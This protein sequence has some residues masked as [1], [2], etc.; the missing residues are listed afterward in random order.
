MFHFQSSRQT[1]RKATPCTEKQ[2]HNHPG[3]WFKCKRCRIDWGV[4]HPVCT[5]VAD[6]N[7]ST[8]CKDWMKAR[9]ITATSIH[10]PNT[11]CWVEKCSH[12]DDWLF[13]NIIWMNII[14]L[15]TNMSFYFMESILLMWTVKYYFS[16]QNH[17]NGH[18][19]KHTNWVLTESKVA[20]LK[21][22]MR[23]CRL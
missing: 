11:N 5:V 17:H 8:H 21:W 12:L 13:L 1:G 18:E 7:I 22:S 4:L 19:N 23:G 14:C 9:L 2:S 10:S 20:L 3:S 6:K 15:F 16:R